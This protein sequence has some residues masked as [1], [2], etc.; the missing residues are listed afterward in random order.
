MIVMIQRSLLTR[1]GSNMSNDLQLIARNLHSLHAPQHERPS[2]HLEIASTCRHKPNFA[3]K[4]AVCHREQPFWHSHAQC[5]LV[6]LCV[7]RLM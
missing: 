7:A 4:V 2:V 6:L 5:W 3:R 1:F